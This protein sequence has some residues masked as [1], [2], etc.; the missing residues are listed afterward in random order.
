MDH[1]RSA[2]ATSSPVIPGDIGTAALLALAA[3]D[4]ERVVGLLQ[5]AGMPETD[6]AHVLQE[7]LLTGLDRVRETHLTSGKRPPAARNGVS[8][9][10]SLFN[11]VA[12]L[13]PA[14]CVCADAMEAH[15]ERYGR[16]S[17]LD[18][19]R[20]GLAAFG[21]ALQVCSPRLCRRL[22]WEMSPCVANVGNTE[23]W[24]DQ[25]IPPEQRT[26]LRLGAGLLARSG[27]SEADRASI[28]DALARGMRIDLGDEPYTDPAPESGLA[29]HRILQRRA[30]E[31]RGTPRRHAQQHLL[32]QTM[33]AGMGSRLPEA[34][35]Q[36]AMWMT[37]G[38]AEQVSW[39]QTCSLR[40]LQRGGSRAY[41]EAGLLDLAVQRLAQGDEGWAVV[42]AHAQESPG[43]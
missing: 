23:G 20:G 28:E 11:A 43:A 38:D 27:F 5:G 37:R 33:L 35:A 22:A 24:P 6:I 29:P 25:A 17:A 12:Q 42:V 34:C 21:A 39:A 9:A 13:G 19:G 8:F 32:W 3:E 40:M 36:V 41:Q 16:P 1:P 4:P 31:T 30:Q 10:A 14:G 26:R 18:G 15:L 2:P 7:S